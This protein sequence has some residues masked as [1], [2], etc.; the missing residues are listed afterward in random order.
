MLTILYVVGMFLFC[1]YCAR[2]DPHCPKVVVW[3]GAVVWPILVAFSLTILLFKIPFYVAE[4]L[5]RKKAS[6]QYWVGGPSIEERIAIQNEV[7]RSLR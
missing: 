5:P 4:A 6:Y 1:V 2:Q 7:E 3:T